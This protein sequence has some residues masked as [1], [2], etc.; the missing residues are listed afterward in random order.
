VSNHV[1]YH[2]D[3]LFFLVWYLVEI[4]SWQMELIVAL[5]D[6]FEC[7][8]RVDHMPV[9]FMRVLIHFHSSCAAAHFDLFAL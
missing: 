3:H 5:K 7:R 1:H 9:V 8:Q 4:K 6:V 2:E